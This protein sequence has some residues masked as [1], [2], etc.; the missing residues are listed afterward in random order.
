MMTLNGNIM[1]RELL[2]PAGDRE[3]LEA[4]VLYGADAVYLGAKQFGMRASPENFGAAE[5]ASAV[6]LCHDNGAKL[7]LTCNTIPT[8]READALAGFISEA[9][10]AGIDALIVADIGVL[11]TAKRIAPD[12]ELHISTQA[13]VLN[14]LTAQ[15]FYALGAKRVVLAREL[16]LEDIAEIHARTPDDLEIEVFVHGAMC[17]SFSGRCVLSQYLVGR[18]ANRGQCAQPCRWKYNLVEEKRPGQLYPVHEDQDGSY[19]LNA[20]DLCMIEHLDRLAAA[21]VSSFK[22]EGRAKSAYYVATITNAYRNALDMLAQNPDSYH[23]PQ[24]LHD[25]V[26]KVSHRQYSTGFFLSD[27]PPAQKYESGG[28]I[29]DWELTATVDGWRG[30]RIL[31]TER[32]RF[33]VGDALEILMPRAGCIPFTVEAIINSDGESVPVACHPMEKLELPFAREIPAGS[34]IRRRL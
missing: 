29:R 14:Y 19:I 5:L 32:N 17:M 22:I 31:C 7:Y 25:E 1:P 3:S 8:N 15:E 11:M 4:A 24:W 34:M 28:Y 20:Q 18:D 10:D 6:T 33:S 23:L 2:A 9:A 26:R 21:G 13:G 27:S 30:G 16:A 12:L